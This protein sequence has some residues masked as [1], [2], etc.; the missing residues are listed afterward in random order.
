M[1][2]G[3][4]ILPQTIANYLARNKFDK[5]EPNHEKVQQA[6]NAA[7]VRIEQLMNAP[8]AKHTPEYFHQKLGKILWESCGMSRES[9]IRTSH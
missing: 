7:K 4:F 6:L 9:K 3:Y 5:I 2:D 1:A 8:E